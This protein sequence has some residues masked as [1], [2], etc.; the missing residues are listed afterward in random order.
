MILA[1]LLTAPLHADDEV[2]LQSWDLE[3]DDGGFLVTDDLE[4]WEWGVPGAGPEAAWDGERVWATVL[5][6]PYLHAA[7]AELRLPGLDL[8]TAE[9]PVLV[10]HHWLALG[11]GDTA[12]VEVKLGGSWG[13]IAPVY[14]YPDVAGF[15]DDVSDWTAIYFD[16]SGYADLGAVRLVLSADA[17]GRAD[18]WYV[19]GLALWDGDVVPPRISQ[20]E[21]PITWERTDSPPTVQATVR[22]DELLQAVEL[23]WRE[24]DGEWESAP[25]T[26]EG[27]D[28]YVGS[29][30]ILPPGSEVEWRIEADDGHQIATFPDGDP[31]TLQYALPAPEDLTGPDGRWW[32]TTVPLAWS[33]PSTVQEVVGY[34]VYRDGEPVLDTVEPEGDAPAQG[35]V[36]RYVVTARYALDDGEVEGDESGAFTVSVGVPTLAPLAPATAWQQDTLRVALTGDDLLLQAD[37]PPVVDLGEGIVISN[38]DV[39]HVDRAELTLSVAGN[40]PVGPRDVV[41]ETGGETLTLL[42]GFTVQSGD[43]RPRVADFS[44]AGLVQGSSGTIELV[45]SEP[46][47]AE[48]VVELGDGVVVESVSVDGSRV[49]AT[50]AVANDARV[51]ERTLRVDDGQ[52]IL[53][54]DTPF[55]VYARTV[56]IGGPCAV[57]GELPRTGWL[58]LLPL[59]ALRRRRRSQP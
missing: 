57:G 50:V 34:R 48:P 49:R 6:G 17:A 54:A 32:G 9:R 8:T 37:A 52:R 16:L 19:D 47:S 40:A 13:T 23:A 7:D 41:V 39:V 12:R 33:P 5:D 15:T 29:L 31:A 24:T 28:R 14:G 51:G 25:M 20:V 11:A 58:V 36:D 35:P 45:L 4:Q 27:A 30:P 22:D 1:L 42:D 59:L 56:S 43:D 55:R 44:P 26:A 53:E 18:G 2:L 46:P 10:L 3:A 21:A 38:V